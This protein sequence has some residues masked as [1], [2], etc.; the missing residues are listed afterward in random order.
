[1]WRRARP[2]PAGWRA[3][4][5]RR[6]GSF[7]QL[8]AD[9]PDVA[10]AV[11]A[12]PLLQRK[13]QTSEAAGTGSPPLR[14]HRTAATFERRTKPTNASRAPPP[15]PA[16]DLIAAEV[17]NELNELFF[18]ASAEE[19][20]LILL[21]LEIVAPLPAGRVRSRA[22]PPSASGWKPRRSPATAR[23]SRSIS[24]IRC[25][26]RTRKRA[27]SPSDVLGEPIVVAAKALSMPRDVVYRILLFVNTTVGHSV[28][29]VHALATLY[30][31]MTMQ[32]AEHMVAI[33]QA[34]HRHEQRAKHRPLV[35]NDE[36]RARARTATAAVRRAPAQ[37]TDERREVS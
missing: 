10:A 1:M 26:F 31:E 15:L 32:A 4:C 7:E 30:D 6:C 19:R 28:E 14:K 33:W 16:S 34:L 25:K 13:A 5:R 24:R 3:I 21:N 22:T 29:R 9:L 37:R 17:A 18:A 35:W 23:I 11:R 36:A 2:W 20:R 8:A 27:A 12:H